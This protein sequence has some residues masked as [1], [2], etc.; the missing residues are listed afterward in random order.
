M[1]AI[2][3]GDLLERIARAL[4]GKF[5]SNWDRARVAIAQVR[6]VRTPEART[7]VAGEGQWIDADVTRV[8]DVEGCEWRRDPDDV[9]EWRM[10]PPPPTDD[11]LGPTYDRVPRTEDYLLAAYGPVTELPPA[12]A[13][14]DEPAPIKT[15]LALAMAELRNDHDAVADAL[16]GMD[17]D[18]LA[19]VATAARDLANRIDR[20]RAAQ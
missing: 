4:A 20:L 7:W 18:R 15:A 10:V 16:T 11:P 17:S 14:P 13:E 1:S 5:E 9:T 6:R 19:Q 2:N 8:S 3:D 12:G